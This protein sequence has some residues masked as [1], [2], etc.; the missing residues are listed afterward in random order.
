MIYE[1]KQTKQHVYVIHYTVNTDARRQTSFVNNKV[2][3]KLV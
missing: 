1:N 2:I 3:F